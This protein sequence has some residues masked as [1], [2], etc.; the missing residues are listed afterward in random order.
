MNKFYDMEQIPAQQETIAPPVLGEWR[1]VEA[2]AVKVHGD[3]ELCTQWQRQR[4]EPKAMMFIGIRQVRE[5][6]M[7]TEQEYMYEDGFPIGYV[8]TRSQFQATRFITVWLFVPDAYK[9]PVHVLP[10]DA[11]IR[12]DRRLPE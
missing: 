10:G 2:V 11:L 7:Y 3:S 12:P 9:K 1:K 4:I 6:V 8:G 5:G